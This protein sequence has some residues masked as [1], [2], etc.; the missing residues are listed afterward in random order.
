MKCRYFKLFNNHIMLLISREQTF[1]FLYIFIDL[2]LFNK[3]E[4]CGQFIHYIIYRKKCI[5]YSKVY[6][7]DKEIFCLFIIF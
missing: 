5:V 7:G 2:M 4:I 6:F 3:D 1:R